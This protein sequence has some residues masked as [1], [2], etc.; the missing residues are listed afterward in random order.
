MIRCALSNEP[1][2]CL[3]GLFPGW[4]QWVVVVSVLLII[5]VVALRRAEV[6]A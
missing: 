3:W 5:G 6:G 1:F 2:W 4:A